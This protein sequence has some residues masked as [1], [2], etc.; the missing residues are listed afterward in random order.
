MI[1]LLLNALAVYA[2]TFIMAKSHVFSPVRCMFRQVLDGLVE[3]KSPIR[4]IFVA[5]HPITGHVIDCDPHATEPIM[6]EGEEP[7]ELEPLGY[8]FISCR[9]CVGFWLTII[10]CAWRLPMLD[11]AAIY[12]AS[13]FLATQER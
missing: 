1:D 9:M 13:Y 3:P 4:F 5:V 8:D 10:T 7:V 12:G 6:S 11:T 2:V